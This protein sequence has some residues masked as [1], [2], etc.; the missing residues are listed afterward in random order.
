MD[1]K[2]KGIHWSPEAER[3]LE[4]IFEFYFK[5]P[6]NSASKNIVSIITETEKMVFT[7]QWQ[8]DEFDPTC[9]RVI[10]KGKFRVVYKIINE[11]ILVTAV[12]PT[13][14]NPENFRKE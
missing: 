3:D 4:E 12:Y 9:R 7:K 14:K 6:P 11:F 10:V 8:V 13:K 5:N 1:D 2:V